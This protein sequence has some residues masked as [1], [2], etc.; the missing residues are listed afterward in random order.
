[1]FY[2]QVQ[3]SRGNRQGDSAF[4]D[5]LNTQSEDYKI[6][7]D[8]DTQLS[9][10]NIQGFMSYISKPSFEEL[11]TIYSYKQHVN[12]SPIDVYY[13]AVAGNRKLVSHLIQTDFQGRSPFNSL[14]V[15]TLAVS[16][17]I[18]FFVQF[19]ILITISLVY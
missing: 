5:N 14:H 2:R 6:Q 13:A 7:V 3:V 10:E 8:L 4:Y 15:E 17:F 18:Y 19:I 12:S 16:L 9:C 1:M 11:E